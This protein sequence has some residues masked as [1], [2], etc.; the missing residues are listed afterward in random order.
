DLGPISG[1]DWHLH[2]QEG[3]HWIEWHGDT[4]PRAP[5]PPLPPA[6]HDVLPPPP[7]PPSHDVPP[8]PSLV[9]P[10]PRPRPRT[11]SLFHGVPRPPWLLLHSHNGFDWYR[12]TKTGDAYRSPHTPKRSTPTL[13]TNHK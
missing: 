9:P 5:P 7:P 11:P 1:E 2:Y 12:D 13:V 10:P 8:S 3:I 4:P 6:S